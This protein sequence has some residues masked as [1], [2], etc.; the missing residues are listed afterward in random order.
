[1][2]Q[3]K[4]NNQYELLDKLPIAVT[5]MQIITNKDNT[6][7]DLVHLYVNQAFSN[8]YNK[9]P[10]D[11]I[12]KHFSEIYTEDPQK[13]LYIVWNTACN[14]VK[15]DLSFYAIDANKHL[16]CRYF[17]V[18]YGLCGCIVQDNTI[19][20][21]IRKMLHGFMHKDNKT[22]LS[23]DDVTFAYDSSTDIFH[24][25]RYTNAPGIVSKSSSDVNNFTSVVYKYIED[26]NDET[27]TNYMKRIFLQGESGN[28]NIKFK[29]HYDDKYSWYNIRSTSIPLENGN[30]RTTG[31]IEKIY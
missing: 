8:L 12:N 23:F 31:I 10:S 17:Q 3:S 14:G 6:P 16:L 7:V 18:E 22:D 9:K 1:M 26:C 20:E 4:N 30:F 27:S 24:Y 28:A 11:F 2:T 29:L 21:K 5:I 15:K 13:Y 19:N 25:S